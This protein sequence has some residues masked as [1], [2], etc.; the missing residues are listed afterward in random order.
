MTRTR[1]KH[2]PKPAAR[3]TRRAGLKLL[4]GGTT[5]LAFPHLW[6]PNTALAQTSGRG[7]AKHLIYI[8]LS[9]GFRFSTAFNA[10]VASQYNPFGVSRQ[11]TAASWGVGSLL[12][13]SAWLTDELRAL[14][15][16]RTSELAEDIAV[17][18][19]VDHEPLAG[20][21]DGNHRTGLERFLTGHANGDLGLFTMINHGLRE[22]MA[23]AGAEGRV[24]LPAIILG[25]PGIGLGA[26]EYAASRPPVLRGGDLQRFG[27]NTDT[28]LP[29]WAQDLTKAYTSR[30][31]DEQ[32]KGHFGAI[33]AYVQARS[34]T[35]AYSEI[36]SSD[37]LKIGNGSNEAF[38]GISNAELEQIFGDS[39]ASRNIQVALRLFHFGCPAAYLDQGGYDMHSDEDENL[40]T[41]F[42]ELNRLISALH[43]ALKRMVHPTG[44]S[45][46]DH[47]IVALGSEFSRTARGGRF[48]S[49]GGSD[50]G[51]DLA[52]RWMSMPFMGGPIK[53]AGQQIGG[54]RPADLAAEGP[55]YSYR[56]TMK[57]LFDALDV[58]H[59]EFFPADKPF[60]DLFG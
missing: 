2:P 33:E 17:I 31:H 27:F 26:G 7:S 20:S 52:T 35:R 5:A 25:E 13:E 60:D 57:T 12:D 32:N 53:A 28:L 22:K 34:A 1:H 47:V 55:V 39:R 56:A 8:R 41:R 18:P 42:Q 3:F 59:R 48:N 49:A 43:L 19:C 4:G 30:F 24:L 45:Y 37:A 40:P 29:P 51:G 58:D 16:R 36:F 44:G 54:T 46:W 50:H 15:L 9:G 21:A 14:G 10:D 6:I 11:Q 38:D 23:Q